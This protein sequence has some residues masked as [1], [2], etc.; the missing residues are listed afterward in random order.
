MWRPSIASWP[1]CPRPTG[2][3]SP[4]R[5]PPWSAT[6]PTSQSDEGIRVLAGIPGRGHPA[7][8]DMD[9]FA[10]VSLG[11]GPLGLAVVPSCGDGSNREAD[12]RC[13]ATIQTA[14][15]PERA[16]E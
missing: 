6:P 15:R 4:P 11:L 7:A 3:G 10:P 1:T 16:A 5:S 9:L 12:P 13:A 8:R 2:K 14:Q